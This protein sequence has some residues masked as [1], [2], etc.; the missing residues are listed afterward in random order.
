MMLGD[1]TSAFRELVASGGYGLAASR[2]RPV[3]A[4]PLKLLIDKMLAVNS[5]AD[6]LLRGTRPPDELY[7]PAWLEALGM[8]RYRETSHP[9]V[10]EELLRGNFTIE[11]ASTLRVVL[12]PRCSLPAGCKLVLTDSKGRV[13]S[14]EGLGPSDMPSESSAHADALKRWPR[15]ALSMAGPKISFELEVPEGTDNSASQCW[16]V[17]FTVGAKDMSA[18]RKK[19]LLA[20]HEH[21]LSFALKGLTRGWTTAMDA[22]LCVLARQAC[23]RVNSSSEPG[24][25]GKEGRKRK[26]K[27]SKKGSHVTPSTMDLS[28]LCISSSS[29]AMRFTT[30]A[31]IPVPQL[32]LRMEMLRTFNSTLKQCLPAFALNSSRPWTTGFKLRT[33]SH[34]IF[35]EVKRG[36]LK[37]FLAATQSRGETAPSLVLN[38][39]KQTAAETS[40]DTSLENGCNFVQAFERFKSCSPAVFRNMVDPSN[41]KVFEVRFEGEEGID[42][43]GVYREGLTRIVESVFSPHLCLLLPTPNNSKSIGDGSNAFL[44]NSALETPRALE[45]L[46]F[47]GRFMGMS[48]RH[49][50]CLPFEFPSLV[51]KRLQGDVPGFSDLAGMDIEVAELVS[52]VRYCDRSLTLDGKTQEPVTTEEEFAISFAGLSFTTTLLSGKTVELIP[53]GAST[54]VTLENRL[55]WCELM[56]RTRTREFDT[57]I[58]AI[59]RGMGQV[60]PLRALALFT[61]AEVEELVCGSAIIDIEV[62]K[63]H[64][65]YSGYSESSETVR[66]FWKVFSS[67]TDEERSQYVRFA[68]GR[69][70]LP[71]EGQTWTHEHSINRVGGGSSRSLPNAHT[72]FFTIDLPDYTTEEDMRWG[73]LTAIHWGVGGLL[74]G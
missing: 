16:G 15:E 68:W 33:L 49:E 17:G 43:G 67:L 37:A 47:L 32:R 5:V 66:L 19:A 64:T 11:G 48:L 8:R 6:T 30:L 3:L 29:E 28:D 14:F 38:N 36:V 35:L 4:R 42:A 26:K 55:R 52:S 71:S 40:G 69:S 65:A 73:L 59:R 51:W 24:E 34:C 1:S 56:E 70:R 46:E 12:H 44:P 23:D 57:Q 25:D 54:R 9:F 61:P 21:D 50:S 39:F 60:V 53:E 45:M 13:R 10:P 31:T 7:A 63:K 41:K 74:Q 22:D 62:L 72:C 20:K 2:V 58:A 27:K 18:P